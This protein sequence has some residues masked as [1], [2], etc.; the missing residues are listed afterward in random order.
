MNGRKLRLFG[1]GLAG[2]VGTVVA[3]VLVVAPD[4]VAGALPTLRSVSELVRPVWVGALVALSALLAAW[5]VGRP[6]RDGTTFDSAVSTPPETVSAPETP[7]AGAA[8]DATVDGAVA[9]GEAAMATVV[10]RL[11]A[12]AVTAY[13][14][15][16]EVP[17]E[18]SRRAVTAG[19]WTDDDV[20]AA[21]LAPDLPQPLLA[22]LRLW[23]DPESERERRIRRAVAAVDALGEGGR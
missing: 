15:E 10:E 11:R 18:A 9:E 7:L 4:T 8:L 13:A 23:L 19:A 22:R 3:A 2:V 1:F 21:L 16:A 17:R 12:T 5:V 14:L 20:A 6:S